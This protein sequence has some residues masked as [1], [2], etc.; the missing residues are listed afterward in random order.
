MAAPE[1]LGVP[2]VGDEAAADP[3]GVAAA[4]DEA[5]ADEAGAADDDAAADDAA[6]EG[7]L[8]ARGAVAVALSPLQAIT[9]ELR[10]PAAIRPPHFRTCLRENRCRSALDICTPVSGDSATAHQ[11]RGHPTN[12]A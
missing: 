1:A 2:P 6:V 4:P 12:H 10:E 11:R 8:L 9:S 3:P 7:A 5:G